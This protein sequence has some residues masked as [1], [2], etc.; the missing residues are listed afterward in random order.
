MVLESICEYFSMFEPVNRKCD[1]AGSFQ[2]NRAT[3]LILKTFN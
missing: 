3:T 1:G 2:G